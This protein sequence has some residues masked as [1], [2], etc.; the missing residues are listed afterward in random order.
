MISSIYSLN[1]RLL[2][3]GL[4]KT[5]V[6]ALRKQMLAYF[7][8]SIQFRLKSLQN[9]VKNFDAI[10]SS[11]PN[12]KYLTKFDYFA[13]LKKLLISYELMFP[14]IYNLFRTKINFFI[15]QISL[16][17]N[18]NMNCD[19]Q[20][21]DEVISNILEYV[22]TK[23]LSFDSMFSNQEE[24]NCFIATVTNNYEFLN[25]QENNDTIK[26]HDE[27][28]ITR[29]NIA[30]YKRWCKIIEES[31]F[32]SIEIGLGIISNKSFIDMII[33]NIQNELDASNN[34]KVVVVIEI[35]L[36]IF[37][38][39]S[40]LYYLQRK[41]FILIS[42]LKDLHKYRKIIQKSPKKYKNEMMQNGKLHMLEQKHH[43][44]TI[45]FAKKSLSYHL[46]YEQYIMKMINE[47]IESLSNWNRFLNRIKLFLL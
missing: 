38:I 41:P 26:D 39:E 34:S 40:I 23:S 3:I 45:Y 20:N 11:D 13:M 10:N 14:D 44:L 1:D 35:N 22:N 46:N 31:Y 29:K 24:K 42:D 37:F 33:Q 12:N 5:P 6:I 36:D 27:S 15:E 47:K 7:T 16:N 2:Y 32:K 4:E 43:N 19:N 28:C 8:T 18:I 25:F 9:E 21:L 30:N 17:S